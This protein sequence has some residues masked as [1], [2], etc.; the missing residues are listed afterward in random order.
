MHYVAVRLEI[1]MLK[2]YLDLDIPW[3]MPVPLFVREALPAIVRKK[4]DASA[5]RRLK[6]EELQLGKKI[7]GRLV[8]ILTHTLR[9]AGVY[10]GNVLIVKPHRFSR[11]PYRY[12]LEEVL[13]ETEDESVPL[14]VGERIYLSLDKIVL[15]RHDYERQRLVDVDLQHF[16]YGKRASRRH[17]L[18]EYRGGNFYVTDLGSTNGTY[19]DQVRLSPKRRHPLSPGMHVS[20]GGRLR[21]IF[22][23]GSSQERGN[24]EAAPPDA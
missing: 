6:P 3:G 5:A 11:D 23:E 10:D 24:E 4:R 21:F 14:S 19:I 12:Y 1:P 17:A 15:G 7:F 13:S 20:F 9:G 16:R 18:I 22:R 8:P 2:M